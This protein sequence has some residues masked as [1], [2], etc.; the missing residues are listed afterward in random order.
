[1]VTLKENFDPTSNGVVGYFDAFLGL[2]PLEKHK[3]NTWKL[4]GKA[5]G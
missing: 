2:K 4:D 5:C 3:G 1:V